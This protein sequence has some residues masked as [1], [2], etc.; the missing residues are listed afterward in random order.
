MTIPIIDFLLTWPL[1][2]SFIAVVV[3]FITMQVAT[4]Q[5]FTCMGSGR[6]SAKTKI[7][8]VACLVFSLL[9]IAEVTPWAVMA[10]Q[11]SQLTQLDAKVVDL[12]YI[13]FTI[14]RTT[15]VPVLICSLE[16]NNHKKLIRVPDP[17]ASSDTQHSRFRVGQSLKVQGYPELSLFIPADQSTYSLWL[18]FIGTYVLSLIA[19]IVCISVI[20]EPLFERL[21]TAAS[22]SS[23]G[24]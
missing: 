20:A 5:R 3:A 22:R 2:I 7:A 6:L 9:S 8:L 10:A 16:A 24:G 11:R 19:I 23:W 14:K 12:D 17:D 18:E 15:Y 13:V 4:S 21:C 1:S